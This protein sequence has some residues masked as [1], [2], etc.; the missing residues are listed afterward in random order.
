MLI[1]LAIHFDAGTL[2]RMT[3]PGLTDNEATIQGGTFTRSI[4]GCN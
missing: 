3:R 1:S 2:E 4:C